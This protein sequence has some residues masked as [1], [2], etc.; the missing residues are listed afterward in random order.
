M[1]FENSEYL[2]LL[3]LLLPLGFF[4][5]ESRESLEAHF[6]PSILKKMRHS[7]RRLSKKV[8]NLLLLLALGLGVV[9][10]ARP[11]IN[12]G[13]VKVESSSIDVMVGFDISHSMFAEDVYPNRFEFAK[14]KF[15]TF[16]EEM[17]ESRIG[18]I[19]FSSKAF[20]ISPLTKDMGSLKF[21][22]K[23][24]SFENMS[25]KGTDIHAT[26]EVTS[27]LLEKQKKK[28]LLLFTDGGDKSDY[29]KE[30]AYAKEHGVSVFIY[31]V[32]TEKG[33]VIKGETGVLKDN[34]GDIVVVK[35]NDNIRTLALESGG[36]YLKH[37]MQQQ[38]IKA[39]SDNIKSKFKSRESKEQ[40]IRDT[41]ELFMFPLFVAMI[42][43]FVSFSS[44]PRGKKI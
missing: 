12:N 43:L 39:L 34:K 33:G 30:I 3:L 22:V 28:A 25:L 16:L 41:Q 35:R 29:S 2:W 10:L 4:L 9:A 7:Q 31:T 24:M 27:N 44:L 19:G 14:R 15:D 42:F 26:L 40:T 11:I 32:G 37:S 23:N 20:L 18:V 38:D 6:D 1:V 13:E 17:K 8:R 21:L 5:K 36:A